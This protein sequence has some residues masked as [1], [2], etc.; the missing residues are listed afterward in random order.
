MLRN[1]PVFET[2]IVITIVWV[3]AILLYP[4]SARIIPVNDCG[5]L[6]LGV[7]PKTAAGMGSIVMSAEPKHSYE[8]HDVVR[9]YCE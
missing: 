5:R 3:A 7:L 9:S 6:I 4:Y 8:I 1:S 2:Q